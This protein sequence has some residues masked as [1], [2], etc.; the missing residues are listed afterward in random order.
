MG[1]LKRFDLQRINQNFNTSIF[2]ETGTWKGD[3]VAY[4]AK[5][6]FKKIYSSEVVPEFA[7]SAKNRFKNQDQ[8]EIINKN[9]IDTLNDMLPK[10]NAN[11][12]FW[13]DAHYPGADE[14]LNDYN[15]ELEEE[16]RLPLEREIEIIASRLPKFNDVLL[17]DDLRIYEDGPF[18]YGNIPSNII[19]PKNR[20]IDFVYKYF[21]KT[22]DIYKSYKDEGYI[23]VIPKVNEGKGWLSMSHK[24]TRLF[25]GLII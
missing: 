11:C 21:S 10:M 18:K 9:S 1:S 5:F 24:L 22:H 17:I 2:F 16:I 20:S 23:Y 8:I 19:H 6:D 4:A 15:F 13:L 3:G 25:K 14:G 7:E 12:I